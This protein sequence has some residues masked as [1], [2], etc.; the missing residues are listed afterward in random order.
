MILQMQSPSS[1]SSR[2]RQQKL[3]GSR[4]K[5]V[6]SLDCLPR[7]NSPRF[8]NMRRNGFLP[9]SRHRS[10]W[11]AHFSR[12]IIM[13]LSLPFARFGA[14]MKF[15]KPTGSRSTAMFFSLPA[16][17]AKLKKFCAR[18]NSP[19]RPRP[20]ASSG[21]RYSWPIAICRRRG[22]CFPKRHSLIRAIPNCVPFARRFW[23][24]PTNLK[25]R[26]SNIWRQS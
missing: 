9:M 19:A 17:R 23:K 5:F 26:V 10:F 18:K 2:R 15:K 22:S 8:T 13:L 7:R 4:S 1:G 12:A 14:D 16:N 11:N 3:N 24:P 6:R 25:L 20:R 21:C